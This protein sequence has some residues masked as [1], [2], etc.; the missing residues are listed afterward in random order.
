MRGNVRLRHTV[1]FVGK[2]HDVRQAA[3]AF[4]YRECTPVPQNA[5]LGQG[6]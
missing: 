4:S 6:K 2:A 3:G 5:F 1:R